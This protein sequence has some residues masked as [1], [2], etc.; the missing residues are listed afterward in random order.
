MILPDGATP[1]LAALAPAFTQPTSPPFTPLGA[2][3]AL[4]TGRRTVANLLR[5]AGPLAGGHRTGYQRAS[6]AAAWSG[7]RLACLR[8]RFVVGHLLPDGPVVPVGDDTED[9]PKGKRV[10]PTGRRGH[11]PRTTPR[12]ATRSPPCG[13]GTGRVTC[14]RRAESLVGLDP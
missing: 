5:A 11:G 9:G 8:T 3:A 4:A 1:L 14:I 12:A 2:A 10:Y 13:P 6:S 7:L